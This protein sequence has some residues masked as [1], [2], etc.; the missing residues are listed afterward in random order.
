MTSTANRSTPITVIVVFIVLCACI[1]ALAAAVTGAAWYT[2]QREVNATPLPTLNPTQIV[3]AMD[4]IQAYVITTRGLEPT[5]PVDRAFLTVAEVKQRVL[6]DFEEDYSP[7]EA[8][9]DTRVLAAFGLV[10]PGLDLYNLYV[11][12]YSEGVAGFYDPDTHELVL[13]SEA[14][15]LNAYER[16]VFAH[17]VTHALQDQVYDLRASGFSDE[18]YETDSEKAEAV[19]AVLEGDASLLEEQYMETLSAGEKREYD[20]AVNAQD[21]SLYYEMPQYLLQD[22]IFPYDQ[23]LEFVR[24]YY[25]QDG[26]AGVDALWESLPVSSEQILHPERYDAGDVPVVVAR[27]ALTDTLGSGWRMLD[28]GVNG[29]W[30]T[31]LIL[32]Y[33]E[34]A[35]ARLTQNRAARAAEGWGG[36]GYVVYGHEAD[37]G[38]VLASHWVWDTPEDAGEFVEAFR[39]YADDRFGGEA[40]ETG[41]RLCW[42]G[43]GLN[44]LLVGDIETLWVMA[45]E[46]AVFDT[47]LAE[48]PNFGQ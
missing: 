4:E 3:D 15:G 48:Y 44:C 11:R 35:D 16:T 27:P 14:Q 32:A 47:V 34:D 17:E 23:G 21:I 28:S 42:P 45:P 19:Q 2:V 46:E 36:D 24:H 33:G 37:E 29:E 6:D 25:D 30:Y 9:D 10:E 5:E 7:E 20:A 31:Y 13:V 8:A 22:F 1:F 41:G 38:L 43:T 39:E 18:M 40:T 12:L 26:W